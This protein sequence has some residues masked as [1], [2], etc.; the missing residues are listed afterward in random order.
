MYA[1]PVTDQN[2]VLSFRNFGDSYQ[3]S[4]VELIV[5]LSP[6][7]QGSGLGLPPK[8][9]KITLLALC[10]SSSSCLRLLAHVSS[11][12]HVSL[13]IH[14]FPP[15]IFLI[16]RMHGWLHTTHAKRHHLL[17]SKLNGERIDEII[18]RSLHLTSLLE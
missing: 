5:F 1:E 10:F 4:G 3:I 6:H 16:L 17:V 18:L 14:G 9:G 13:Q 2:L 7:T 12:L 15:L 11:L 8:S